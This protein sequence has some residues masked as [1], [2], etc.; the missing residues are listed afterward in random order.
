M[1]KASPLSGGDINDAFELELRDG[2]R[3][4]LKTNRAAP[5]GMFQAEARGLAWLAEAR[6]LHVPDV[7]AVADDRVSFL[8]LELVEPG[9]RRRAFDEELGRALAVL[10]RASPA[11][12]GL[13]HDNFIGSLPQSNRPHARWT[14]FFQSERLEPQL[15]LATERGRATG[16]MRRGFERLFARL[17]ALVGPEEPPARLHGDLWGGNLHVTPDGA[18]CLIDPA[19]YGG[20][21]EVDLAMMRLFGGFAE[22]V[23]SAYSE[24]FP[25]APGHAERVPLYQLYPLLVHVNLFGGGYAASVERVL[26]RYV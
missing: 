24:A 22:R 21:R 1:R 11:T 2:R 20:H 14:D 15:R 10:H 7:V 3:L 13:D 5:A 4:F 26:E 17:A 19:A 12:F 23:F 18:P 9:S 25:L 16:A 6:A 8:V